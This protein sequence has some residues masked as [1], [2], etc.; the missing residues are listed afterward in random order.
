MEMSSETGLQLRTVR[1]GLLTADDSRAELA[2]QLASLRS[3]QV[4][5]RSECSRVQPSAHAHVHA[6]EHAHEH[7]YAYAHR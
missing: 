4:V 2:S 6:H 1:T 5:L 7:A 3:E